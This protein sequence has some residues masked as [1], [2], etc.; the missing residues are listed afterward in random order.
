[1]AVREFESRKYFSDSHRFNV[2]PVVLRAEIIVLSKDGDFQ[3][4]K[5]LASFLPSV[6]VCQDKLS[7]WVEVTR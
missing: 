6:Q 4:Q 3:K 1:M 7:G 5:L 2:H